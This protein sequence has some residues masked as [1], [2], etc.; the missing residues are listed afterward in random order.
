MR[1]DVVLTIHPAAADPAADRLLLQ[2]AV[3]PSTVT[4]LCP[5]CGGDHGRPLVSSGDRWVSLSRAGGLVAIAVSGV[6]PL[7]LD[8][9]SRTAASAHPLDAGGE[10]LE[11]ARLWTMKE[12]VLKADG[13]GLRVDPRDLVIGD[14][15]SLT[16]WDDASFP[17][18]ELTLVEF[19]VSTDIVGAV[20]VVAPRATI[21]LSAVSAGAPR[22]SS[23]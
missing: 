3:A 12:A 22:R 5:D 6:G 7:G 8:I 21:D 15:P 20:A 18:A 13:R 19:V 14:G 17:L 23:A 2:A 9:E 1:P 16:A 11:P 10:P 4:Q